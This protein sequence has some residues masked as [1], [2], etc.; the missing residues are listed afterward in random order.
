[1]S[2]T[3][4]P[5]D[6]L[7]IELRL[8]KPATFPFEHGGVLRGLLSRAL[9]RHEFPH[10]LIPFPCESGRVLYRPGDPYAFGV[11]L[12]GPA[13][14]LA[15]EIPAALER[16][17]AARPSGPAPVLGGNYVV[18]RAERLPAPDLDAETAVLR[19]AERLELRFLSPLRLGRPPELKRRG[20]GFLDRDCFPAGFFLDRL[21]RRLFY[22]AR[23]AY[24][25]DEERNDLEPPVPAGVVVSAERLLWNDL[26]VRGSREKG[27][28]YTLGGVR[29]TV[30]LAG[31]D[32]A[33]L[34]TLIAGSYLHAGSSTAYGCGRYAVAGGTSAVDP[35]VRPGRTLLAA[36]ADP[37]V[38]ER[39][40]DHVLEGRRDEERA[41]DEDDEPD[42]LLASL[43]RDLA[44]GAYGPR[45]LHS[46]VLRKDDG[47]VRPLAV[48]VLRD[49]VVQRAAVEVL[50]PAIDTLLEEA[51][52][53]YRRGFSR[54][55]AA[56][57]VERA[58]AEGYRYVL[59]ADI[60]AFFDRVDWQVLF[61]KLD[62]LYPDE[63]LVDLLRLWVEAPVLFTGR[64]I[65][66]DRGLPQGSPVSP[67]LANLYL[68]TFDEELLD[69]GFRLVRFADDFVVLTKDPESARLAKAEV[70]EA[71]ARLRLELNADET[72]IRSIDDGFSY[73]G[74]LFVRSLVLEQAADDDVA[75]ATRPLTAEDVPAGS[76]LAEVPLARIEALL[77]GRT[78]KDRAAGYERVPLAHAAALD[79]GRWPLYVTTHDTRVYL[80]HKNVVLAPEGGEERQQ[81]LAVLS[82]A[83][84]IGSVRVTLPV[85]RGLARHGIPSFFCRAS[86]ELEAV[87]GPHQPNWHLWQE[88]GRAAG[89]ERLCLGFAAA[90]VRARLRNLAAIAVR[91]GW[92]GAAET[93]VELR[94][95]ARETEN[96][97]TIDAVRGLEGRGAAR[98]W[99]ALAAS[100]PEE[101]GFSGRARRPPPDPVNALLSFGYTL[102]YSHCATALV[103]AGL[104]PR[105][106]LYHQ[107]HGAHAALAS[108]LQE[109]MRH[110]VESLVWTLVR[111]RQLS[112]EDFGPSPDGR[113]PALLRPEGRRT[114]LHAFERRLVTEFTP[115]G[116]EKALSY[117]TFLLRQARQIRDLVRGA[118]PLYE[119]LVLRT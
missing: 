34:E 69:Q 11:T 116:E 44:R 30:S 26:P 90:V 52:F 36:V 117:R 81:P 2:L 23:G 79:H 101:W 87:F 6:R 89:D 38:L 4:P 48:P 46:F 76:W 94:A 114:F 78:E 100:L 32:D 73:L 99:T 119:P 113:F 41:P 55:G 21:W 37:A 75:A 61:A 93:A 104:D 50:A 29:G 58:Y 96:K 115:D 18:E 25:A 20:A 70:E 51:S 5:F 35:Y 118:R 68:D 10:G 66:R 65:G 40:L 12:V 43:G 62:A 86:G 109:E 88:Q 56:R 105:I 112:P 47:G 19:G 3:P 33:W 92:E 1:M 64:R 107:P 95:L 85:L 8:A 77:A 91:F 49:K 60:R 28:S 108:D 106:G 71:L 59:D 15:D 45:P 39:A 97:S 9:G 74:Y 72:A 102:L 67:L 82:H 54:Q 17:G 22:L 80:R 31:L 42:A 98:A 63:P 13:R 27:R 24:P 110:V 57:A 111:R 103:E 84:F 83:V 14:R 7:R 16:H 53:A